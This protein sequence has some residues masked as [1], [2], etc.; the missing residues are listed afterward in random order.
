MSPSLLALDDPPLLFWNPLELAVSKKATYQD[1]RSFQQV[2]E[3]FSLAIV[4]AAL[5]KDL[6][7]WTADNHCPVSASHC[8]MA[9]LHEDG[10]RFPEMVELPGERCLISG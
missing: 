3:S 6:V 5:E 4:A 8:L 10:E 1:A 2:V 9:K 7:L